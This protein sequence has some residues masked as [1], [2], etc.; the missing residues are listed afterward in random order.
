MVLLPSFIS[1]AITTRLKINLPICYK[2]NV[3][4]NTDL[5]YK[6][7]LSKCNTSSLCK[8][9]TFLMRYKY[10]ESIF[11]TPFY[12][13][14]APASIFI[15]AACLTPSIEQHGG[16]AAITGRIVR[17]QQGFAPAPGCVGQ[18]ILPQGL[19][20]SHELRLPLRCCLQTI[21]DGV[22]EML[23]PRYD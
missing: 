12:I 18:E 9:K 16:H 4:P 8:Y 15:G 1:Y 17:F 13:V 11:T 14:S 2:D 22:V 20:A 6:N 5:P 10:F 3:P 21:I 7:I 23:Q 19:Q